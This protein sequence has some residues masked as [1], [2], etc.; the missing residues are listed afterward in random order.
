M[1]YFRV[2]QDLFYRAESKVLQTNIFHR[3]LRK[4]SRES[5]LQIRSHL[6]SRVRYPRSK[7]R[8]CQDICPVDAVRIDSNAVTLNEKCCG[9]EICI[10]VCP[11]GVFTL[12]G[13]KEKER[14]GQL[15]QNLRDDSIARFTCIMDKEKENEGALIFPCLAGIPQAYLIAPFAWQGVKVQI[16]RIGCEQCPM[17]AGMEQYNLILKHTYHLLNC[18]D[19]PEE[20]LEEVASFDAP[21][22]SRSKPTRSSQEDLGR[23]EFFGF[24]RKQAL[25]TTKEL[26]S[27]SGE[28]P[29]ELRWTHQENPFRSFLLELLPQ[30]GEVREGRLASRDLQVSDL[31][32]SETCIGCNVC[33]TICPSG[34]IR[35]EIGEGKNGDLRLMFT[36]SKCTGCKICGEACL[37][38]AISFS[39]QIDLTE[40]IRE[41]EREL[42]RVSAKNCRVCGEPFQGTPGETCPQCFGSL[43]KGIR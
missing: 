40:F 1:R 3:I 23:R 21:R 11:N 13:R 30:M 20:R 2:V 5:E 39:S 32:V 6:C 8:L 36:L 31:E 25:E 28:A 33:E 19:I 9:C 27:E 35:R 17:A 4:L 14:R 15:Q 16:K 10:P 24:F 12:T 29:G 18:F 22:M 7:C 26:I 34:A 42:A 43:R 38:K 41:E 37:P